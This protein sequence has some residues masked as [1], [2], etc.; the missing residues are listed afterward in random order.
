MIKD[1][2]GCDDK[3]LVRRER[4][5]EKRKLEEEGQVGR[6]QQPLIFM[7]RVGSGDT[8]LKSSRDRDMLGERH[9]VSAFEMECAGV[10]EDQAC[11]AVKGVC[12]YADSHKNK[13]W[14]DF[15]A[16]TSAAVVKALLERYIKSD[17]GY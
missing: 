15:A 5:E 8:V 2:A 6:A 10:W 13:E 7:G 14:Q 12:D 1:L 3:Y 11:I 17:K 9:F 4:L 16:A